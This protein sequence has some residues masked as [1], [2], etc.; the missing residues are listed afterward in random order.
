MSP[1]RTLF[2]ITRKTSQ[3]YVEDS[4]VSKNAMPAFDN[5]EWSSEPGKLLHHFSFK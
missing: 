1:E 3:G 5:E 2:L 4:S